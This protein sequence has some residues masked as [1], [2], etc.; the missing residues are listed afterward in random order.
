MTDIDLSHEIDPELFRNAVQQPLVS[1]RSR[2]SLLRNFG[3]VIVFGL[4]IF[5]FDPA[6]FGG[7]ALMPMTFGAVIG[8]GVVLVELPT[9]R[10]IVPET[11]LK[12][13]DGAALVESLMLWKGAQ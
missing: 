8:A 9:A 12:D 2:L 3:A 4:A 10:L 11:A 5:A 7:T 1:Q 13:G 6:L